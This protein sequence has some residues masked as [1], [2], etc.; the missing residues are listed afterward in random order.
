MKQKYDW[1]HMSKNI[2][3]QLTK[4]MRKKMNEA[5]VK[6]EMNRE[7]LQQTF[8]KTRSLG[9]ALKAY[10]SKSWRARSKGYTPKQRWHNRIKLRRYNA[11]L[12]R[13]AQNTEEVIELPKVEKP[14]VRKIHYLILS[15]MY[16][17]LAS[18]K[19]DEKDHTM[20]VA[21]LIA[22]RRDLAKAT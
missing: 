8:M 7:P 17:L 19:Q 15:D 6:E 11:D 12:C 14:G 9:G 5:W 16:A 18:S 10:L 1:K 22:R 4:R 3:A 21:F 2:S 13:E 20:S